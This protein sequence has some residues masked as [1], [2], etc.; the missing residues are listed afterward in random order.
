MRF[1]ILVASRMHG[2]A[3]PLDSVYADF[4]DPEG[5]K[6][7][8]SMAHDMGFGGMLCVHP[9]QIPVVHDVYQPSAQELDWA[10]RVVAHADESGDYTFRLDGRMVDLPLIERARRIVEQSA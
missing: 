8:A 6:E 9:A 10:R 3:S 1:Q 2:L 5:L 4:S 7:T